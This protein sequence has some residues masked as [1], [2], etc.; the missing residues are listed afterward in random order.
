MNS[1]IVVV[2]KNDAPSDN[3]HGFM[4]GWGITG[5][6]TGSQNISMAHGVLPPGVKAEP[7]YHLFETAIY[8][9]AGKVRVYYGMG[10]EEFEDVSAGDFIF[11]PEKV[12][13]SPKNIGEDP[14]EFIV[15]RAAPEEVAF[16]PENMNDKEKK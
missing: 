1:N 5:E 16:T 6:R 15:A 2:R 12:I 10:D 9:L 14:L 4:R 7:H 3:K 8:I 13:H 11:I